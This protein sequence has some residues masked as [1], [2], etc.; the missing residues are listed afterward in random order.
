MGDTSPKN[1]HQLD[2][3]KHEDHVKK[4]HQKLANAVHQHHPDRA[5]TPDEVLALKKQHATTD[6]DQ[7]TAPD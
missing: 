2:E 3:Q 6:T 7:T 5:L 4:D 1:K